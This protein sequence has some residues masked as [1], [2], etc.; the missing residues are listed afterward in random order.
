MASADGA[1]GEDIRGGEVEDRFGLYSECGE[2]GAGRAT[3][4]LGEADSKN[5]PSIT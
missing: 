1:A 2:E 4:V 5:I 3:V